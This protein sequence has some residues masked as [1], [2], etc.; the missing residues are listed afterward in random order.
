MGG[1]AHGRTSLGEQ[2]YSTSHDVVVVFGRTALRN[3]IHEHDGNC[4]ST[5]HTISG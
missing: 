1:D 2:V 3:V 5:I 4:W